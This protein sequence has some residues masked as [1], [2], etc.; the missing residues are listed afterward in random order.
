MKLNRLEISNFAGITNADIDLS[1]P[2]NVILGDN[3]SGKTSVMNA[4]EIVVCEAS[5]R[6][7]VTGRRTK[8]RD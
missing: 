2:V 8:R 4:V 5:V 7:G 1:A 6:A 3:A